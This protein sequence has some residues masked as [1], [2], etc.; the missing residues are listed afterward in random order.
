MKQTEF[1][2]LHKEILEKLFSSDWFIKKKQK[3]HPAYNR[4][5]FCNKIIEQGVIRFPEQKEE[6]HEIGRIVLDSFILITLSE[7]NLQQLKLGSLDLYG[8]KAVKKK[9]YSRITNPEQY[10]DLMVELYVG[11]YHKTKNRVVNPLEKEGYPD[12]RIDIPNVNIPVFIECKRLMTRSRNRL[13]EVIKKANKQIKEAI[14]DIGH[15]LYGVI[16]LD[17]STPVAAGQVEND[18]LSNELQEIINTIQNALSGQKNR[19]VGT[20]IV[21]WDDYMIMGKPP[22][23]TLVVFRRRYKRI[24]HTH[25]NITLVIPEKLPLF[26]GYT[27]T[28]WL[29][30]VPRKQPIKKYIFSDLFK[31]EFQ[32]R[33]DISQADVIET[34]EKFD[35]DESIIFNKHK[36]LLFFTHQIHSKRDFFILVCAERKDRSLIIYWAF[37]IFIDLCQEIQLLSPIQLLARFANIYGLPISIG[38]LTSNFIF[39]HKIKVNSSDPI[40]FVSINNPKNHSFINCFLLKVFQ[41]DRNLF[42]A[43][44]ALVFCINTTRYINWISC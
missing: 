17:V 13:Q 7:G 40:H 21:V 26:E 44:C 43:D 37:K 28:Q 38:K 16:V 6:L 11:A 12:L 36:E 8:D 5:V 4:W 3:K 34:I 33:F 35:K 18:D 24:S 22:D 20:A 30:W 15:P 19:S 14:K 42:I 32:N 39:I 25:E 2:Q 31:R 29:N 23:G 1:F 9:I 27:T 10:E 41:A